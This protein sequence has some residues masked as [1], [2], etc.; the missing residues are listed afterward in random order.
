MMNTQDIMKKYGVSWRTV[1][2]WRRG[3]YIRKYKGVTEKKYLLPDYS[4]IPC[5]WEKAANKRIM[6]WHYD[7]EKAAAWIARLPSMEKSNG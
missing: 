7:E 6:E 2:T 1:Q 5:S 3:Y 4:S